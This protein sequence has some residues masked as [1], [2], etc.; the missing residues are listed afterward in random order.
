MHWPYNFIM[1]SIVR[2]KIGRVDKYFINRRL[3]KLIL[4][5]NIHFPLKHNHHS[6]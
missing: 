2:V 4:I 1:N 6:S 5:R 3:M